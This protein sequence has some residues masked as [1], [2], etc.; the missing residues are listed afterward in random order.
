MGVNDMEIWTNSVTF[1]KLISSTGIH[2]LQTV[3]HDN[4]T[5]KGVTSILRLK[6]LAKTRKPLVI[7]ILIRQ[8][9]GGCKVVVYDE[10]SC[11]RP[12]STLINSPW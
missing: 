7:L 6:L 5:T 2:Y 9:S 3:D 11:Q 10:R 1:S 12:T 4:N 8:L